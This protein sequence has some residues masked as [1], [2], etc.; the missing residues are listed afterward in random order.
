MGMGMRTRMTRMILMMMRMGR[1]RAPK[2][3]DW[4]R[5]G[6]TSRRGRPWSRKRI[7]SSWIIIQ[8]AG[9]EFRAPASFMGLPA[10][11]RKITTSSSGKQK[12]NK[13]RLP[14]N[15]SFIVPCSPPRLAIVGLT[16]HYIHER[17][18]L[19]AYRT[20][21]GSLNVGIFFSSSF[22]PLLLTFS[23]DIISIIYRKRCRNSTAMTQGLR[24]LC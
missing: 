14:P 11:N 15:Q 4:R 22:L 23:F 21:L 19:E 16:D 6:S 7:A 12:R 5:T 24:R 10:T 1:N 13:R 9:M 17:V 8:A 3:G 2:G 18:T 20:Y